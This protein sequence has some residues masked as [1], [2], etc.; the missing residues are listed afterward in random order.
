MM[1]LVYGI[2]LPA[3]LQLL[4]PVQ[5]KNKVTYT[6]P[7]FPYKETKK[8]EAIF[9]EVEVACEKGCLGKNG[10]SKITCVRQC[11]S[12]SC[13]RDLYQ[14]DLLEDGEVDVRLNSFKGCFIQ[15]YNK[16]RP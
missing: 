4:L 9:R 13:Y 12:P 8:N 16:S 15:R 14:Q 1:L 5:G 10:L 7:E 6:F 3:V 2:L 11:V